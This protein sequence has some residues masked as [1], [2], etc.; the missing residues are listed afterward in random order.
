MK[1]TQQQIANAQKKYNAMLVI[2]KVSDYQP[3]FVG[4]HAAEQR[5]DSDNELVE[6]IWAGDK[7]LEREWK[8][9]FLEQEVEATRKEEMMKQRE[10]DAKLVLAPILALRKKGA[11]EK[12][13]TTSRN[14]YAKQFYS[15]KY[16]K[17]CVDAFLATL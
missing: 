5:C 17:E 11:F 8:L 2:K 6:R 13:I 12:W 14:P 15:K 16:T 3:E 7:E 9:F 4:R 10:L 1:Y